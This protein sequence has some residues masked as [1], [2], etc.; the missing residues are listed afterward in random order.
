MISTE[1]LNPET[2]KLAH[3][4][5]ARCMMHGPCGV[6]FP[7]APCMEDGKCTKQYP[8]KFQFEMTTDVNGYPIYRCRDT[9]CTI[10]VHGVKLDNRWV[11]PHNV[12]LSTKYDA[13]I[14]VEVCNNIRA[15]KYLFKY[16][17]KGHDHAIVEISN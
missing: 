8:H 16:V 6:A 2:K 13:H 4:T 3:E 10:L 7:N 17:Y 14:N 1:L 5:V 15:V 11:V 9:G 12:Y